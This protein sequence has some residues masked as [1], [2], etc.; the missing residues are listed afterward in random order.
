MSVYRFLQP[1]WINNRYYEAGTID[2][3]E[4]AGGTLPA[5]WV[6]TGQVSPEDSQAIQD[7]WNAGVQI[8]G[9]VAMGIAPPKVY[10][11]PWPA[12]GGTRPYILTGDGTALGFRNWIE[13]R[14]SAPL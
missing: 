14:G 7:F 12:G 6:P 10:W 11:V 8:L 1:H 3:T 5:G 4:D 13:C 9:K 2:A